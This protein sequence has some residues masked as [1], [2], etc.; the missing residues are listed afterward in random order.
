ML[1]SLEPQ[2]LLQPYFAGKKAAIKLLPMLH[3]Y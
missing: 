3:E 2:M 1:I